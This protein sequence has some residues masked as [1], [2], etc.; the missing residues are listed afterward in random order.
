[1]LVLWEENRST[2]RKTLGARTRINNKLKPHVTPGPGMTPGLG[3]EP[4]A[5]WWKVSAL[6]TAPSLLPLIDF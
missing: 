2:L 3:S 1:M 6:T 4:G 5:H